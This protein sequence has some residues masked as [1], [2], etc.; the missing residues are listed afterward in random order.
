[1]A[2]ESAFFKLMFWEEKF[3]QKADGIALGDK[4]RRYPLRTD[5]TYPEIGVFI[6]ASFVNLLQI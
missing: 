1:M 5:Y 3:G 6:L 2:G 4:T